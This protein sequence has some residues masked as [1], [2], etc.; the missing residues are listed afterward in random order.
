MQVHKFIKKT[1]NA[2]CMK[3]IQRIKKHSNRNRILPLNSSMTRAR[4]PKNL[5]VSLQH[6]LHNTAILYHQIN[7]VMRN[8]PRTKTIQILFQAFK[9]IPRRI[10]PNLCY[11]FLNT[12][13]HDSSILT[14][15]S[16]D[17]GIIIFRWN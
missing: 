10:P 11:L 3:R 9:N 2:C 6:K 12:W 13:K 1:W 15:Q 7:L 14:N 8:S 16:P 4:E 17:Y 5:A